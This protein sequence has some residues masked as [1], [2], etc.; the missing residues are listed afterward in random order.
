MK[1]N[2]LIGVLIVTIV[3]MSGI[4]VWQNK[5]SH[6]GTIMLDSQS[7][8]Q[9]QGDIAAARANMGTYVNNELGFSFD[10]STSWG[11][12][13]IKKQNEE[14]G[15]MYFITFPNTSIQVCGASIVHK[16]YA[17]GSGICDTWTAGNMPSDVHLLQAVNTSGYFL[18]KFE[19]M[20]SNTP[21]Y[22]AYFKG[23]SKTDNISFVAPANVTTKDVFQSFAQSL[24][25]IDTTAQSY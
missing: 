15:Y 24:K 9:N 18:D 13:K 5:K 19:T 6:S 3:L 1:K 22:F 25:L 7:L 2:I 14:A 21:N 4:L 10:Y 17:R 20:Q 8:Q 12:P 11:T 16:P 23:N